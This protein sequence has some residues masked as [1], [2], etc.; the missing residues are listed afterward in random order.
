MKRKKKNIQKK[1]HKSDNYF[2]PEKHSVN[3]H[4][5]KKSLYVQIVIINVLT[6]YL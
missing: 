1:T 3:E 6:W 4:E 5:I 2:N